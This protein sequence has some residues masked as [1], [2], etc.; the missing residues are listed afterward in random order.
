ML[1]RKLGKSDCSVSLLGFGCM[2]LPILNGS[3]RTVDS[4]DP[5][6]VIDEEEATKMVRYAIDQGVNYF[7][8]AYPYHSGKSEPF[9]GKALKGYRE[10]VLLVTK[11]PTW[12]AEKRE[13]FDRFL[14]EQLKR[15]DTNYLDVYLLH[16]LNRQN[17]VRMKEL[18]VLEFLDKYEPT[19]GHV[20]WGSPFMMM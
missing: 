17:W 8:T 1:Y 6:K 14:D 18:R 3:N 2:R 4:F 5:N 20:M 11:L 19:A 16:G 15:L 7:D 10:K 9:L 12:L 13:D